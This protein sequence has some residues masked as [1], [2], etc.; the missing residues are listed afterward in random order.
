MKNSWAAAK[1]MKSSPAILHDVPAT[2]PVCRVYWH[3]GY[4]LRHTLSM[5][6]AI[7]I[8]DPLFVE[9]ERLARK[10]RQSRSS[11]Y[12]Q[13]LREYLARHAKHEITARL[14]RM[15]AEMPATSDPGIAA[16]SRRILEF[17]EW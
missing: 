3:T 8:P 12:S 13:A 16:A 1:G 11:L 14:D 10:K 15:C 6:T 2:R 7:S 9:A 5:K 17:T 4:T